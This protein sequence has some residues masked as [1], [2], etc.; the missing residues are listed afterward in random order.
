MARRLKDHSHPHTLLYLRKKDGKSF[1]TWW[2]LIISAS[3]TCKDSHTITEG[4]AVA[5]PMKEKKKWKPMSFE[6]ARKL[7]WLN[8]H[9][10]SYSLLD[11]LLVG[12]ETS[13]QFFYPSCQKT[14]KAIAQV[15]RVKEGHFQRPPKKRQNAAY[16]ECDDFPINYKWCLNSIIIDLHRGRP[17][18]KSLVKSKEKVGVMAPLLLA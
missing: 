16:S 6:C 4:S 7:Q 15:R 13:S 8:S 1:F 14:W 5:L 10:F 9:R 18:K 3:S 2:P 11:E 17:E 12:R